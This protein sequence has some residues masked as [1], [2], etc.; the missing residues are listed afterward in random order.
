MKEI[1]NKKLEEIRNQKEQVMANFHALNGAEQV[2]LQ[3]IEEV[4]AEEV[5][6]AE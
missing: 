6:V 4:K 3:L 1:L 2:L 5:E